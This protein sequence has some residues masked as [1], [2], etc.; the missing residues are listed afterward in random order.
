MSDTVT[1]PF[2]WWNA[3][4]I[5][6]NIGLVVAGILAFIA[7]VAVGSTLLPPDAEFEV[8]IF[9]ALFQGVGYLVM[10]VVANV[11]YFVGPLSERIVRPHDA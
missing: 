10:I 6:Y 3:R 8:T 9:T 4:R 2:A 11:F 1:S 5:R 7:Y